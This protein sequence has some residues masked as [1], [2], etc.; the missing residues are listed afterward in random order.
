M[1]V[2]SL[3]LGLG[4]PPWPTM[5]FFGF[6]YVSIHKVNKCTVLG[7]AITIYFVL[8]IKP[9]KLWGQMCTLGIVSI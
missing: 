7:S 4:L 5:V 2:L 8:W 6:L 3:S 9:K 1:T